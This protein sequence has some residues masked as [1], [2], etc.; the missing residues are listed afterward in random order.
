MFKP[1][2]IGSLSPSSTGWLPWILG[3]LGLGALGVV[4]HDWSTP[5]RMAFK[6]KQGSELDEIFPGLQGVW[7]QIRER[8]ELKYRVPTYVV[9]TDQSERPTTHD[10]SIVRQYGVD[11]K[12]MRVSDAAYSWGS[13]L[14]VTDGKLTKVPPNFA[15]VTLTWG[16]PDK[17]S[18][19]V[20]V[21]EESLPKRLP[22]SK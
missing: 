10:Y 7:K 5:N 19:K 2:N 20:Q 13:E 4:L 6:V 21:A 11:L 1:F 18:M 8:E 3:A 9:L 22:G 14:G 12:S 17:P 16:G 15:L